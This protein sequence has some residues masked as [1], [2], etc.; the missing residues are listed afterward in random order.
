MTGSGGK[1]SRR[2]KEKTVKIFAR[3]KSTASIFLTTDVWGEKEGEGQRK[4]GR[5]VHTVIESENNSLKNK[6]SCHSNK[7]GWPEIQQ[8]YTAGRDCGV[9]PARKSAPRYNKAF[10]GKVR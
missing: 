6:Q 9:D 2:A 1:R 4:K 3:E 10:Y 8:Q 5:I 7:Y